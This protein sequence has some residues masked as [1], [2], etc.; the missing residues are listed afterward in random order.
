VKIK[1]TARLDAVVQADV[2][3]FFKLTARLGVV[4]QADVYTFFKLTAI[5]GVVVQANVYTFFKLTA[6]LAAVV[7]ADVYTF[8]RHIYKMWVE[9]GL[10]PELNIED[11]KDEVF[12]MAQPEDPL[13]ITP[14]DLQVT[15]THT[16]TEKLWTCSLYMAVF[17]YQPHNHN[18]R[19]TMKSKML[20]AEIIPLQKRVDILDALTFVCH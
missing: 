8:F 18:L 5:L 15:D 14:Q 2:Y 10:Y 11:V 20:Q 17:V 7:Q 19:G 9:C 12:D 16:W 13:H 3:T 6:T 1:L 4:V